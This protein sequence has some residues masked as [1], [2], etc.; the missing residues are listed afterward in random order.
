[1]KVLVQ[2]GSAEM[3]LKSELKLLPSSHF[4]VSAGRAIDFMLTLHIYVP[5]EPRLG[6]IY[7][8]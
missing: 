1:M 3:G 2:P 4:S 5:K 7:T 6:F 8:L